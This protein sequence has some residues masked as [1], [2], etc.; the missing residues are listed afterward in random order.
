MMI[1]SSSLL[2]F[3]FQASPT[4][5]LSPWSVHK[6]HPCCGE[7]PTCISTTASLE[8]FHRG[9]NNWNAFVHVLLILDPY[10]RGKTRRFSMIN[11]SKQHGT[12]DVNSGHTRHHPQKTALHRPSRNI[13]SCSYR[14]LGK[15]LQNNRQLIC[16]T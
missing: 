8:K 7:D 4:P 15:K 16:S 1:V 6:P 10:Q 3:P 14:D 5:Y 12:D 11:H 2:V 9:M 13:H